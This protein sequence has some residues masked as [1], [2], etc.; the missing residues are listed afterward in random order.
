MFKIHSVHASGNVM[1]ESDCKGIT[2]L[3]RKIV[4]LKLFPDKLDKLST[5][6]FFSGKFLSIGHITEEMCS[7]CDVDVVSWFDEV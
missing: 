1:S 6:F 7:I 3:N 4:L 5:G 2:P